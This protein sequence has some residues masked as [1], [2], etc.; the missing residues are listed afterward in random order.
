[1]RR[2]PNGSS[3]AQASGSWKLLRMVLMVAVVIFALSR[4]LTLAPRVHARRNGVKSAAGVGSAHVSSGEAVRLDQIQ[5][6]EDQGHKRS[7]DPSQDRPHTGSLSGGDVKEDIEEDSTLDGLEY[8]DPGEHPK[9]ALMFLT[10]AAIHNELIWRS[11]LEGAAKLKLKKPAVKTQPID[12]EKVVGGPL[13][14]SVPG[15]D[16]TRY[17]G[18]KIQHGLVPPSKYRST[19]YPH[20]KKRRLLAMEK[21]T[22]SSK[23]GTGGKGDSLGCP[24]ERELL[25]AESDRLLN[26]PFYG[27]DVYRNQDLFSIYVHAQPGYTFPEDS[28][29]SGLQVADPVNCTNGFALHTLVL[30][31]F[32]LLAQALKDPRNQKFV[33]LSE[34]CVPVHPP[35]VV[36]AQAIYE[37]KSR[38]HAC[39]TRDPGRLELWRWKAKMETSHLNQQHWR[40]SQQWFVLN[41]AHAELVV[42]DHHVKEVFK[43]YCWS[44]G[45]HICVSDEH[46]I[47]TLLASYNLDDQT[48]CLGTGT[49]TDWSQQGWH[50]GTFT[51]DNVTTGLFE[52]ILNGAWPPCDPV[53]ARRSA[54]ELFDFE[55]TG[56]GSAELSQ[57]CMETGNDGKPI[58][59]KFTGSGTAAS[60]DWVSRGG[61]IPLGY[62]CPLFARKFSEN[63]LE[64]TVNATLSCVGGSQAPWCRESLLA[65]LPNIGGS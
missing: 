29:F 5:I 64:H 39:V 53:L 57:E 56:G 46:Y 40:K 13:H 36:Y 1:M 38:I 12:L 30:A 11:F 14:P 37:S 44:Y 31:E 32:K 17:P 19:S 4:F 34:A 62:E 65:S 27:P 47:P 21:G 2:Q 45:K 3:R 10:K 49:W 58:D 26:T 25:A 24:S 41:R 61:Y 54:L 33:L 52:R 20:V 55:N 23:N 22:S 42:E 28:L 63:A 43:R 50:P 48:D 18:Y 16:E 35:E 51:K 59:R 15:L 8:A 9:V 7:Q 60:D 6:N